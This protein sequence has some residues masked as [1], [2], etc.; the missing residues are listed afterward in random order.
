MDY[1][2]QLEGIVTFLTTWGI[3]VVGALVVFIIGKMV[4]SWGRRL[5]RKGLE[6][7]KTDPTLVPFIS[8]VVYYLLLALVI[9]AVLGIFGIPTASFVALLGAAGLAVGLALQGTLS[10]FAAGVMLLIFRPFKLGDFVDAGGATGVIDSVGIFSTIMRSPDNVLITVPNSKVFGATI[11][12]YTALETRRIDLE[13][14]ISYG[15]DIQRAME[16]IRRVIARD[17]RVLAEPAVQIA[18]G[19][20]GD[21]SVNL[22]VRPWCRPASYWDVRFDLLRS[23]KEGL[24]ANGCSIPYPQTDVHLFQEKT[25]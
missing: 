17:D 19:G 3:R 1:A 6:K 23:I 24:E 14:G 11:K 8:N 13:I 5:T 18:V 20:L 12:N 16:T 4:A 22:V 7:G 9:I 15:D 21:S 2:V 25:A 10:N